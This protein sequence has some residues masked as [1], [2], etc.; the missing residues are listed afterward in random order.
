MT[1]RTVFFPEPH[2]SGEYH[3]HPS[4][5]QPTADLRPPPPRRHRISASAPLQPPP[6]INERHMMKSVRDSMCALRVL[7]V[8]P[9]TITLCDGGNVYLLPNKD[10]YYSKLSKNNNFLSKPVTVLPYLIIIFVIL[11]IIIFFPQ[12][13]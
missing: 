8:S 5:A 7:S 9:V 12:V 13:D 3:K 11:S 10:C 1:M 6:T 4:P 2:A